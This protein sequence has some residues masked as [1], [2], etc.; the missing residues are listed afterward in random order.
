MIREITITP[1]LNGFVC[2]VGCQKV[3]FDSLATMVREI[4][5]YY[6]NPEGTEKRYIKEA[7]NKVNCDGPLVT[8][9]EAGDCEVRQAPIHRAVG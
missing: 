4:E 1:V 3:V 9:A 5:V 2:K 7:I 8:T 6:R